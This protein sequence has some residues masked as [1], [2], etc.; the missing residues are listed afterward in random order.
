MPHDHHHGSHDR[1]FVSM[2]RTDAQGRSVVSEWYVCA[3]L[4]DALAEVLGTPMRSSLLSAESLRALA[5]AQA[6]VPKLTIVNT[7]EGA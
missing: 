6:S 4:A 2:Q 3:H 5:A 7:P 1:V